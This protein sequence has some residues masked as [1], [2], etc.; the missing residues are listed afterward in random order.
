MPNHSYT[1]LDRII[2]HRG[3]SAYAPENTAQAIIKAAKMGATWV[4]VDVTITKNHT[5][6]IFH[7]PTLERCSNGTGRITQTSDGML[8]T[9]DFGSWFGSQFSGERLLTLKALIEI[10]VEYNL[11]L[12]LEIK[13]DEGM[14]LQ[15]II[16]IKHCLEECKRKPVIVFSCFSLKALEQ[17]CVYLSDYPRALLVDNI[18]DACEDSIR[19][20]Q[21]CGLHFNA[22]KTDETSI[23]RLAKN[24]LPLLAYTV[25]DKNHAEQLLS[26][27][28]TAIFSD[29][30]DLFERSN[31]NI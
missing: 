21:A 9:L 1:N 20:I 28:V 25:N 22:E 27:G 13:P 29:Y 26:F 30:P 24:G 10:A 6:V 3:A 15:T 11:G 14:E 16:A 7:D 5:A 18:N 19:K 2:A 17:S 8:N 23:R 12:N 4:E 31:T